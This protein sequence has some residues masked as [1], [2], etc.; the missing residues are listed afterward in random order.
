[1]HDC[2]YDEVSVINRPQSSDWY[3]WGSGDVL[4]RTNIPDGQTIEEH[5]IFT[6]ND[7][8]YLTL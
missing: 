6:T 5:D 7:D 8:M 2:S 3:E 1:M 4:Y